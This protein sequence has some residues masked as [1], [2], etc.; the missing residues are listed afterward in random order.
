MCEGCEGTRHWRLYVQDMIDFAERAVA[1]TSGL[2]QDAFVGDR[3]TYDATLR[4]LELIGEAATRVPE[5]VRE[6]SP[7]I[8]WRQ[9]IATRN[10][11]AH[12]YQGIDDDVIWDIIQT[13]LP[14][15]LIKARRLLEMEQR[16][17][18]G[19]GTTATG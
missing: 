19:Y 2:D 5:E 16:D 17:R 15:L 7:Q 11:L 3:R 4:N 1:Y 14:D 13:D 18:K 9:V 10:R 6:A 12:A 8:K